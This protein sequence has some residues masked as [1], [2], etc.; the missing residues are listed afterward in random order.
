MAN[1]DPRMVASVMPVAVPSIQPSNDAVE[2]D[3]S[4]AGLL[5]RAFVHFQ[6]DRH[7]AAA[8]S[9]RAAIATG[10]LNDAGRALAYWHIFLTESM[11]DHR[12]DGAEALSS[13][14][15]V[16]QDVVDARNTMRYAVTSSGDFIE[17]FDLSNR[18]SR[19]RALLSAAWAD[20]VPAFGRSADEPVPIF[21][22]TE[23][24]YFLASVDTC[25][26]ASDRVVTRES[27]AQTQPRTIERA[28]VRCH[29]RTTEYFIELVQ[30]AQ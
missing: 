17:R 11:L 15:V 8:Q 28:V 6:Q 19:A 21:D 10:N 13:F 16:G 23:L 29:G 1:T 12:D 4:A 24:D 26:N 22:E 18:L 25:V 3:E 30:P 7:A 2:V 20:R 27:L 5:E 9:F 14:V